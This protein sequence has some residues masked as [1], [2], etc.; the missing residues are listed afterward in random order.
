VVTVGPVVIRHGSAYPDAVVEQL[1]SEC[2]P[3]AKRSS[4]PRRSSVAVSA[5]SSSG[6]V[7]SDG[8]LT[9]VGAVNAR[10][11]AGRG[12]AGGPTGG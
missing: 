2:Y 4:A 5:A 6:A 3:G 10:K 9:G 12:A 11:T 8:T 1:A 7:V